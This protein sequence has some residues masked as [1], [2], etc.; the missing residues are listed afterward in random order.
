MALMVPEHGFKT[1]KGDLSEKQYELL[2]EMSEAEKLMVY[3]SF[4]LYNFAP[5]RCR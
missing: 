2:T 5:S 4:A 1:K 3:I